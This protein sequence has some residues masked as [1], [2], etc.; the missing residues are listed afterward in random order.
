[1]LFHI[2]RQTVMQ[3]SSSFVKVTEIATLYK[4]TLTEHGF[5]H[6]MISIIGSSSKKIHQAI[7]NWTGYH[8]FLCY[9]LK[10]SSNW[11]I[12]EFWLRGQ[13]R[14]KSFKKM[15]LLRKV[16]VQYYTNIPHGFG[17]KTL[18]WKLFHGNFWLKEDEILILRQYA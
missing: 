10:L 14:L 9:S 13:R 2:T 18:T 7:C 17:F 3:V 16:L 5:N 12:F 11:L 8:S 4:C 15:Q 1:M 6:L